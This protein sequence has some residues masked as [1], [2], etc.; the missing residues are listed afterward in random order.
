MRVLLIPY[1][2]GMLVNYPPLNLA[3][4]AGALIEEG[5][6]VEV[7]QHDIYHSEDNLRQHL[8]G[9]DYDVAGLGACAGYYQY[10]QIQR[11]CEIIHSE[12]D[13][14]IWLGGH[15][16]TPAPDYFRE[17]FKASW[18]CQGEYDYTEDLDSLPFPAWDLFNID[19]YALMRLPHA[20]NS[21]RCFP[22]L[23]GRGC[24]F[25]CTFCYRM[26]K[27]YRAHSIEHILQE[28][29]VLIEDYHIN[30]IDFA[31]ELLMINPDRPVQIAEAM[32]PLGIKWDC[33]GRLNYAKPE[34]LK[35]MKESG[36]VFINY[37]IESVDDEVL[38][39]M[40]KKL[41]YDQII[42]GVEATLEAGI[43]PGL[44]IIWGN[45]GDTKD[46]L[47]QSVKF[48]LKYDDHAQLRTIRPV[49]P[50]PGS[51]LYDYAI[52][53]GLLK[54]IGDFYEKHKNSDLLTVNFTGLSDEE[55]HRELWWANHL[56]VDAYYENK[57]DN[58]DN[59][60]EHLYSL[61]DTN[62][63]GFRQT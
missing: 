44:N 33:N 38:E 10:Q 23:G 53:K 24:P 18:V 42:A 12:C 50:Y 29:S 19:Y 58:A 62:F 5:D 41:R 55:F 27:G 56:L 2:N 61:G 52:E 57:L 51:P 7:Y 45:L 37:G 32:K 31:D 15:L 59:A 43:S 40:N 20:D 54:D 46:T 28:V 3:Y 39:L 47:W 25:K 35:K 11:L 16:V 36:C 8:Q 22:V 17:R 34:I 14:Q 26:E 48:L 1:D 21:D 49:T 4:V 13:A 60:M 9:D 6:D 63:R 30:Y